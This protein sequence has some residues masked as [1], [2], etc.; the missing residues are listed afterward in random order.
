MLSGGN[1]KKGKEA[2]E[3]YKIF[4]LP[5]LATPTEQHVPCIFMR[6]SL[7]LWKIHYRIKTNNCILHLVYSMPSAQC[8]KNLLPGR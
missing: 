4:T 6:C 5:N 1:P 7:W 2:V 8:K 3:K